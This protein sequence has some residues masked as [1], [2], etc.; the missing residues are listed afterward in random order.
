MTSK[1]KSPLQFLKTFQNGVVQSFTDLNYYVDVLNAPV[2]F[3]LKLVVFFYFIV[4]VISGVHFWVVNTPKYNDQ[5]DHTVG[6]IREYYPTDW[7]FEWDGTSL[8]SF[9]EEIKTINFPS[10][11]P[12]SETLPESL[13]IVDTTT[14]TPPDNIP[15]LIY[16]NTNTLYVNSLSGFWSDLPLTELLGNEEFSIDREKVIAELPNA[17]RQVKSSLSVAPVFITAGMSIGL[18]VVRLI[19]LLFDVIII[20]FILSMMKKPLPY[21]KVFQLS[22]HILI[23]VEVIQQLTNLIYPSLDLPM[24]TIS[25]W[26]ITTLILFHFRNLHMIKFVGK[27]GQK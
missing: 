7:K 15:A 23:P 4:G 1:K 20:H 19:S 13:A 9:P 17:E 5:I 26:T 22:L 12:Q 24:F 11:M 2:K 18:F 14:D 16:V 25:F 3:S 21:K 27:K 10:A 8:H 6:E